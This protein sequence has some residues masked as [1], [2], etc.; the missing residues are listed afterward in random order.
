[1]ELEHWYQCSGLPYTAL[2]LPDVMVRR[3]HVHAW[4]VVCMVPDPAIHTCAVLPSAATT[5]QFCCH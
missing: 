3:A 2:R 5:L 1:M 4:A